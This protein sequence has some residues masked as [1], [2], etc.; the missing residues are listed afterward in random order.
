MGWA[1]YSTDERYCDSCQNF[2][3]KEDEQ[4]HEDCKGVLKNDKIDND[5]AEDN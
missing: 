5:R 4:E 3:D 1:T 2:Y